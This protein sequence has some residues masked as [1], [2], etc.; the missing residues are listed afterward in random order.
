MVSLPRIRIEHDPSEYL[1]L[2]Q[3][4]DGGSLFTPRRCNP[5]TRLS[6]APF[7][8]LVDLPFAIRHRHWLGRTLSPQFFSRARLLC[9]PFRLNATFSQPNLALLVERPSPLLQRREWLAVWSV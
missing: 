1:C 6:R 2:K 7:V 5:I 4:T 9:S 8:S 3:L